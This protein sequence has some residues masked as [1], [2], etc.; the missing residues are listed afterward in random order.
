MADNA[1]MLQMLQGMTPEQ[2]QL[3]MAA[4]A[5][6]LN[7]TNEDPDSPQYAAMRDASVEAITRPSTGTYYEFFN[8]GKIDNITSREQFFDDALYTTIYGAI[9]SEILQN[10]LY[11]LLTERAKKIGGTEL[12]NAFKK[13]CSVKKKEIKKEREAEEKKAKEEAK[14]RAKEAELAKL[15]AGHMTEYENLPEWCTGNKYIGSDWTANNAEGVY[16]LEESGN[17]TKLV[18]ACGRP[19]LINHLLDPIDG[20]DGI[21][22]VEIGFESEKGWKKLVVERGM[23]LNQ[24]RAIDLANNGLA[25]YSENVRNFTTFMASMLTESSKRNAIPSIPSS[26]KMALYDKREEKLLL[27]FND[28]NFVFEKEGQFPR[29]VEALRPHGDRDT[30]FNEFK[31]LRKE[32]KNEMFLKFTVA[33]VLASPLLGMLKQNGFVCNLYGKTGCGK[34]LVEYICATLFGDFDSNAGFV[35]SADQTGAAIEVCADTLNCLP[36]LID[37]YNRLDEKKKMQFNQTIM[38]IAN[39]VGR[40]R[41]NKNLALR[42]Q[43]SWKLACFITSEQPIK[44]NA[45]NGGVSN[46]L[47]TCYMGDT[48]PWTQE[49]IDN[50]IAIFS[51]NY[52]H[53]GA[54]YIDILNRLGKEKIIEKINGHKKAL[55]ERAKEQGKTGKQLNAMAILLTAD[56][57][58]ATELFKD[59]IT[60]S[61]DDALALMESDDMISQESRFYETVIDKIYANSNRIEGLAPEDAIMPGFI[62]VFRGGRERQMPTG[63]SVN[64]RPEMHSVV[65]DLVCIQKTV[66]KQWA[67]ECGASYSMFIS[68]LESHGLIDEELDKNGNVVKDTK[69]TTTDDHKRQRLVHLY[70]PDEEEDIEVEIRP[71]AEQPK[72]AATGS[73]QYKQHEVKEY[74]DNEDEEIPFE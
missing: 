71:N 68:Y 66:L 33:S 5:N 24:A 49:Q 15:A 38:Q 21:E 28:E 36:L 73:E 47:L 55:Y 53:A 31:K 46:R 63:Q 9:K 37:D 74:L 58:A 62:G 23:L 39:G 67:T 56:E 19:V 11:V 57:I 65:M 52:G 3:L 16:K 44:E 51:E 34:S 22:R 60:I 17:S 27:P 8:E 69:W 13:N 48:C 2:M 4:M 7:K 29:L 42:A 30:Y 50:M 18:E 41:A 14:Q 32:T 70:I 45:T 61:E 35:Y 43:M 12:V 10:Q 40:T 1:M 59:G 72:A 26:G 25:V 20:G 64:G 54:E 6:I